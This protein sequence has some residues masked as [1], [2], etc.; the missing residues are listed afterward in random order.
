MFPPIFCAL[1]VIYLAIIY[2]KPY[3][4]LLLLLLLFCFEVD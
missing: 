4:I 3:S 1:I 2:N